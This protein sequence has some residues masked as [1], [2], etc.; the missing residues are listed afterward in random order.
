LLSR[1]ENLDRHLRQGDR[2]LN[3]SMNLL[4]HGP[5]GTGKSELARYMGLRLGREVLVRRGSDLLSMWVG[6]TEK[7][8]AAAFDQAEREEAVLVI[9]EAD[10]FL[11][12]RDKA[13]RS[14]EAGQVNEFLTQMERF[15]GILICTTNRLR[16]L[17]PASVRR[18]SE[19]VHF[20]L[21]APQG[22]VLFYAR[23]LEPLAACPLSEATSSTLRHIT[24][25]A[26]GDFRVV[27]DR[28]R[29]LEQA[30]RRPEAMVA[31]LARE[32][33][34]KEKQQGKKVVG[35]GSFFITD[36]AGR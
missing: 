12:S 6:E 24:G 28:Y 14:W 32:A 23:L 8:I 22:V 26:P 15:R 21:L 33:A 13:I 25:L 35:F 27:R 18:F 2:D 9:D 17:D 19:K 36:K 5:P 29:L 4:F 20:D 16:D 7:A 3:L 34:L 31:D 11:F 1:L 10:G 30:Q